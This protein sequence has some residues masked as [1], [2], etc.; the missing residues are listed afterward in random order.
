MAYHTKVRQHCEKL[1]DEQATLRQNAERC[2]FDTRKMSTYAARWGWKYKRVR[3]AKRK[4]INYK[5]LGLPRDVV[6]ELCMA[7][8]GL[9]G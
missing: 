6:Q 9:T 2:G 3:K 8:R 4:T 1:W 5:E 7:L